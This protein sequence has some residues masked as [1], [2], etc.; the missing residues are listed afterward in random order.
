M[1]PAFEPL[2]SDPL[3]IVIVILAVVG[4]AIAGFMYDMYMRPVCP[5]CCHMAHRLN[6]V[7]LERQLKK[8]ELKGPFAIS[9][10]R[11]FLEKWAYCSTHGI[12]LVEHWFQI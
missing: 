4:V 11:G 1:Q 6:H 10:R 3:S 7:A 5:K 2:S 8:S 9:K 12:F